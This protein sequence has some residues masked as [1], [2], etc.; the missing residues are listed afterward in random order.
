M[1]T[2]SARS[3]AMDKTGLMGFEAGSEATEP[4]S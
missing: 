3:R 4:M 2:G 1:V